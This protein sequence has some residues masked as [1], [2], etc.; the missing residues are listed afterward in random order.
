M[1]FNNQDDIDVI[2]KYGSSELV[3][4]YNDYENALVITKI[5]DYDVTLGGVQSLIVEL[6]VYL[7]STEKIN[8]PILYVNNIYPIEYSSEVINDGR[9]LFTSCVSQDL[10]QE[11][12]SNVLPFIE[13]SYN[14]L[15]C[16]VN[17][18]N[19]PTFLPFNMFLSG[20]Q[21]IDVPPEAEHF[22]Q[23]QCLLYP[24]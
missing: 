1:V 2:L 23:A 21:L 11:S 24:Q 18:S 14:I 9:N 10:L 6:N 4:G 12:N 3:I 7:Q 17:S 13:T 8:N 19:G 5:N 22:S 20:G 15:Y 16:I